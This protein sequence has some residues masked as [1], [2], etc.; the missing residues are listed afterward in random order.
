MAYRERTLVLLSSNYHRM[1]GVAMALDPHADKMQGA[2]RQP[3]DA[4][5]GMA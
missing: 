5:R 3:S 1:L 4:W 2:P